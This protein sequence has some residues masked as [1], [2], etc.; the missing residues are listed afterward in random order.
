V[1]A[2]IRANLIDASLGVLALIGANLIDASRGVLALIGLT[3]E[4]S[5]PRVGSRSRARRRR[6][7]DGSTRHARAP[8]GSPPML[9]THAIPRIA[10]MYSV[11]AVANGFA[12]VRHACNK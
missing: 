4:R 11:A 6:R 1:L 3:P 10:T 12:S 2:L 7:P 9:T 8:R 5:K